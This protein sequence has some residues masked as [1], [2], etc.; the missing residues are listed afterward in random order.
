LRDRH[1]E[2]IRSGLDTLVVLCQGIRPV[3]DWLAAHPLPFPILIDHDRSRARRWGVY[4]ALSYDSLHM[5]RPASFV[6]DRNGMVRYAR[7]AA[8]Q[9]DPAPF[10]E[11]LVHGLRSEPDG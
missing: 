5:A 10:D 3:A 6:V 2:L 4:V 11:I 9:L 7:V 1:D 8:H